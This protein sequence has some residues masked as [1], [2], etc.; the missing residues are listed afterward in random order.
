MRALLQ[1]DKMATP[2]PA[3]LRR[4]GFSALFAQPKWLDRRCVPHG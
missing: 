1:D 2:L 3:M 4:L